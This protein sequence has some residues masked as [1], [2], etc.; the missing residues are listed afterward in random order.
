M[1]DK[2]T[3]VYL[4]PF[5]E[6]VLL[7]AVNNWKQSSKELPSSIRSNSL[8]AES[9]DTDHHTPH[10]HHTLTTS[11]QEE[12]SLESDSLTELL[13]DHTDGDYPTGSSSSNSDNTTTSSQH[14]ATS[15]V[16]T[17]DSS[18][19][20][21]D[22]VDSVDTTDTT[23]S[24]QSNTQQKMNNDSGLQ[25]FKH[26][27]TIAGFHKTFGQLPFINNCTTTLLINMLLVVL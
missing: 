5:I 13:G 15:G 12:D 4:Q 8:T 10:S 9:S 18:T 2:Y 22:P 23:S 11:T 6:S 16:S 14:S 19:R 3:C 25:W 1:I 21:M 26:D 27:L 7:T 24:A 17:G 20:S